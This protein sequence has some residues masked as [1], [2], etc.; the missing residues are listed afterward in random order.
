MFG[1][2]W[3][4]ETGRL[5]HFLILVVEDAPDNVAPRGKEFVSVTL[6]EGLDFID[7]DLDVEFGE[8]FIVA[9]ADGD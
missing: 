4:P 1:K 3:E 9:T 8:F 2:P 5:L 7:G 6:R